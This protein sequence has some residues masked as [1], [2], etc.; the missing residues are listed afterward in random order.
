MIRNSRSVR[1][2]VCAVGAGALIVGLAGVRAASAVPAARSGGGGVTNPY[3]PAYGHAYRHGVVPTVARNSEMNA[4]AATHAANTSTGPGTLGYGGGLPN[5]NGSLVGVTSGTPRVYLVFWGSQW[6]T[7]TTL[8]NGDLSFP[9]SGDPYA[10][11]PYIQN[12]F[13][14]LGTGGELW[15]GT[16]TQYCDGSV[17]FGATSCPSGAP[18]VGYPTGG[19]LAGVWYDN[20]GAAPAAA[21]G[22]QLAQEAVNAAANFKNTTA[23]SNRY[24]QYV[25]LSPTGTDPDSYQQN[26]FCAWHDY[27]NDGYGVSSAYGYLAFTNMPYVM[28]AGTSCGMN[29]VNRTGGS[30]D[31]YSIVEGHEYAETLTDQ[32][33]A[34][35]WTNLQSNAYNGEEVGDECAW[36]RPGTTGGAANVQMGNGKYAMQSI[37]SNDTNTCAISHSVVGGSGS[38][39][40][41]TVTVGSVSNQTGIVRTSVTPV[42]VRATDS[43]GQSVTWTASGLPPGLS[44]KSTGLTTAT[45]S[46][47]PTHTG[48]YSVKVTATDVTGASGSTGFTWTIKR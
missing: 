11:A 8:G 23:A 19:D 16:M 48:T 17:S 21:T 9:S 44:I 5:S 25:I 15:S 24:T 36:I 18:L 33:P 4:W 38:G 39:S 37:W 13:K 43:G 47:T 45:I 7:P 6:G 10:G 26:G 30:L 28:D 34:G 31:G 2:L 40:G 35:G 32:F 1:R 22:S 12:L 3:S 42:A 46:G 41:N 20:S 14:G 27:T 29:F